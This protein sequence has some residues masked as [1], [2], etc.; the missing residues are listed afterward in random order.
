MSRAWAALALG[1]ALG[2]TIAACRLQRG[3]DNR[4]L[5]GTCEGACEHYLSCKHASGEPA[6]QACVAECRTVFQDDE[7]LRAFESLTCRD[8]VEYVE[9]ASGVG[10]GQVVGGH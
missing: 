10:P 2:A 9:G 6:Q 5:T 4:R 7:S 8:T 3:V 1:L